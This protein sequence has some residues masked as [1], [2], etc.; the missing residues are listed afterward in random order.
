MQVLFLL[1]IYYNR[2]NKIQLITLNFI[3]QQDIMKRI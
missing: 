3:I 2:D 1:N